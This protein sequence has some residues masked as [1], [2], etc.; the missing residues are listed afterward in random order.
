MITPFLISYKGEMIDLC[1]FEADSF[2][3]GGR[4]GRGLKL[5]K[6]IILVNE[7]GNKPLY[8]FE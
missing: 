7:T 2:P 3:P 6:E 5:G 1:H 8:F 4:L